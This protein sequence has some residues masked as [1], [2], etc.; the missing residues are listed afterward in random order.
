MA[1]RAELSAMRR[2]IALSREPG[3]PLGPNPRVGAVLIDRDG[4]VVAEGIHRGAG[5]P[6]AE[7]VALAAAGSRAVGATAVITLEPCN[8]TG[9]TAPCAAAL[10]QAGVGRVVVAQRDTSRVARGGTETMRAAGIDVEDGVLSREA[11]QTNVAWS[12]ALRHGRP[13]VS[14]KLAA[15]LDGR[16]AAR[17]GSSQWITGPEARADVHRL[18]AECD[19]ILVGTG[20]ALADNPRL[21]VR[22]P[23][24]EPLRPENQP[25]RVVMGRRDI[26]PDSHMFD[27]HGRSL[28]LK[29]RDPRAAL[30]ALSERDCHHVWLEG[31]PSLAAAFVV[32][33][34]VERVVA[35]VAP[36]LLGAGPAAVAD[37]GVTSI[38][39]AYRL[40]LTDVTRVGG[41]VRLTMNPADP[42]MRESG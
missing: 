23:T 21:T 14:W 19:A 31:G 27:S 8:H 42:T 41:D 11:E 36:A 28:A 40:P 30:S 33:G 16:S 29:T 1:S 37:L 22:L 5:T 13:Y 20:T 7:V 9:R 3:I 10:V 24:G 6:H 32:A 18:R 4:V 35:Y 15:S 25:L 17:D 38:D 12:F 39:Q 2:A 34:L 26:P